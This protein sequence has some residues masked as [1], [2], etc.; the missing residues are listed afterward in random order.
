MRRGR[1]AARNEVKA[2]VLDVLGKSE[3]PITAASIQHTLS[4]EPK[5][6]FSW[7]TIQK[8]LDELVKTNKISA[9]N[10]PHSKLENKPGLTVYTLKK[11]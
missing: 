7:N 4:K 2:L 3:V 5:Q 11:E 8:Y 6:K 9:I 10:L 1:P